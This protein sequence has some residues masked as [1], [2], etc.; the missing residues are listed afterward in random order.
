VH[1]P[2]EINTVQMLITPDEQDLHDGVEMH[3][4]SSA[5]YKDMTL[6]E[7]VETG[8]DNGQPIDA[9]WYGR[10]N[11]VLR[12]AQCRVSLKDSPWYSAFSS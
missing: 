6:D 7:W 5:A 8:Q 4:R 12:G 1:N 9:E 3:Q 2:V 10:G 11:H